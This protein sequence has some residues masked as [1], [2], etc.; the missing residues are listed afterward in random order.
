[1][2]MQQ[3]GLASIFAMRLDTPA[4]ITSNKKNRPKKS[5]G[6]GRTEKDDQEEKTEARPSNG[7]NITN[8]G[9]VVRKDECR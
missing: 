1:M 3:P 9:A 4:G 5:T 8:D 7:I 6:H 2:S